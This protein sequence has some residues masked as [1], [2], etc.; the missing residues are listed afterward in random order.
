MFLTTFSIILEIREKI[1]DRSVIIKVSFVKRWVFRMKLMKDVLKEEGN[2]LVRRETL[3]I[4]RI[5]GDISLVI[6][7]RT[8]VGIGW[9]SQDKLEDWDSKLV[10]SSKVAGVKEVS[11]G[12]M[13][14]SC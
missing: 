9:R 4:E 12:V 2:M 6:F 11:G 14:V 13:V 3:T 1:G 10:I 8:V 7:F 5:E